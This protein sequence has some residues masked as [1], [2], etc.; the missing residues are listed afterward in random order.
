MVA[1]FDCCSRYTLI[2]VCGSSQSHNDGGKPFTVPAKT[3]IKCALEFLMASSAALRWWHPGGTSYIYIWYS[4]RMLFF[5]DP[6]TSFSKMCFLGT[7]PARFN[8]SIMVRYTLVSSASLRLFSGSIRMTLML[9]S[10]MTI[11]Y[12]FPLLNLVGNC[13]V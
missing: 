5:I 8:Q 10:T 11:I 2:S 1:A 12:L 4:S 6:N 9:I 7:I 3:L 13:P